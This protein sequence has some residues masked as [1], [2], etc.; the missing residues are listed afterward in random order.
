MVDK[1]DCISIGLIA[2]GIEG[3]EIPR[4]SL[5]SALIEG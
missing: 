5:V 3:D 4:V 2:S 1:V